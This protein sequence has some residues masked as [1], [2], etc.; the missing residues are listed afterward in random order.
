MSRISLYALSF[1]ALA[2]LCGCGGGGDAKADPPAT[3]TPA[4]QR[5]KWTIMVFLNAS[6]SLYPYAIPNINQMAKNANSKDIRFIVQWKEVQNLDGNSSAPFSSTRRYYVTPD[7]TGATIANAPIQDLGTKVDMG[8]PSTLHDFIV[9]TKQQYPADHYALVIWNH[10]NGWERSAHPTP[11]PPGV[12]YDDET[13][14]AIQT[15]QLGT[16]L[17]DQHVD[18]LS[19]DA[20]CM[21]MLEIADEVREKC[22]FM[23]TSEE[24]TPAP[25]YPYDT[26]FRPFFNN[27]SALPSTLVNGFVTGMAGNSSYKN[28]PM[29]QSVVDSTKIAGIETAV[30]GLANALIANV[31]SLTTIIPA[32]RNKSL[33]YAYTGDGRN[34]YDL[35]QL[36]QNLKAEA[37]IPLAVA[38]AAEAVIAVTQPAV[39]YEAHSKGDLG[40]T[41]LA[42]DF[43]PSTNFQAL[44][45]SNLRLAR[46]THWAQWLAMAP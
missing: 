23:A 12:S 30:D 24:L 21:Q 29:T 5:T 34:F 43:S 16:A 20:C 18:V 27:P 32:V 26:V 40:S 38:N 45:Y 7:M 10:G 41:G 31:A 19:Y 28:Q 39:L 46:N 14:H 6:N 4:G 9:W 36:C 35:I 44:D 15:W 33:K 42:I 13:R 8:L 37:G 1:L 22:D 17:G 11:P 25:G 2:A 3:L